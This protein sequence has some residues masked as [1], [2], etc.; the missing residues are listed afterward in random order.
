MNG[1]GTPP[2]AA[3]PKTIRF[4]GYDWELLG[5]GSNRGGGPVPIDPANASVD[6]GGFLHLRTSHQ[7]GVWAGAELRLTSSLG[8][9]TYRFTVQDVSKFELRDVLTL[10][11]WDNLASDE[12]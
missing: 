10:F 12:H 2:A 7:T 11:T 8:L 3:A 6:A 4:S 1:V 9:G 5:Q